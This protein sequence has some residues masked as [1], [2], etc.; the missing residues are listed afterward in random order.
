MTVFKAF[1]KVLN[2]NKFVIILYTVILV[3]FGAFNMKTSDNTT[4]FVATKPDILI[5]NK[6]ENEGITKNLVNYIEKN[7]N[8]IKIEDEEEDINDALF[9]REVNYV[10]YIPENYRQDFL[11]GKNLR[12]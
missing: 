6:D 10:I 1:L 8:I 2:K 12:Y 3:F 9:Y 7:S 4:N 5:I 11:A